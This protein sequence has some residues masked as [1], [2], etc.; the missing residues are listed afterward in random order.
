MPFVISV[1]EESAPVTPWS[2]RINPILAKK[3]EATLDRYLVAGL[4]Q[5][6]TYQYSIPLMVIPKTFGGV[7][8]PVNCK[9]PNKICNLIQLPIPRVE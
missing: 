7:R 6:P 8:I 4:F 5:H 3:V 2:H 9:K 1:P